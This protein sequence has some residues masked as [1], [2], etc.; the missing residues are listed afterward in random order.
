MPGAHISRPDQFEAVATHISRAL[1][2]DQGNSGLRV[3]GPCYQAQLGAAGLSDLL[4]VLLSILAPRFTRWA[5]AV[6]HVVI[7]SSIRSPGSTPV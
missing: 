4:S 6:L 5:A 2:S 1:V 3:I 7:I